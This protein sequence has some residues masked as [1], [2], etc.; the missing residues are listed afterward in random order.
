MELTEEVD[1]AVKLADCGDREAGS[2]LA[3]VAK[4]LREGARRLAIVVPRGRFEECIDVIR[5]AVQSAFAA[6]V[7]VVEEG[8]AFRARREVHA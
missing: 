5:E 7:V 3:I 1:A 8:Y 4:Q 2:L 6:T